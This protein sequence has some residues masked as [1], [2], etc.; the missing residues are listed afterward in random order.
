MAVDVNIMLFYH[1]EGCPRCSE[2]SSNIYT[3]YKALKLLLLGGNI[4]PYKKI[5]PFDTFKEYVAK[6]ERD[7][8][9]NPCLSKYA[10]KTP[11]NISQ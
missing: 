7:T 4:T 10:Q 2:F 8:E 9:I 1:L 3:F 5:R 6:P 11:W